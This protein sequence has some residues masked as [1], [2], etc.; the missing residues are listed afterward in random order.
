M[1]LDGVDAQGTRKT[2]GQLPRLGLHLYL[3]CTV[4]YFNIHAN[5]KTLLSLGAL[6]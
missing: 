5:G 6:G 4:A 3:P 2:D 1:E